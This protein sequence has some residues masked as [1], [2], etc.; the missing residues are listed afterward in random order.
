MQNLL[1]KYV[2]ELQSKHQTGQA[3]EGA[4]RSALE[5]LLEN[6]NKEIKAINEPERTE[7][8]APDLVLMKDDIPRGYV[9]AKDV[10]KGLDGLT[11]SDQLQ[12]Y[13]SAFDNV[14]FTNYLDFYFY[15]EGE[16]YA[17]V[18]IGELQGNE[19]TTQAENFEQLANLLE[20][21]L[22][23]TSRSIKSADKL[24]EIMAEK[25][26]LL[27]D[28]VRNV[29]DD[30]SQDTEVH[31]QFEAFEKVL[32]KDLDED[33]FADMYA[34]TIV[35]GLLA[36][37]YNDKTLDSFSR[38]EAH[39]L[40]PAGNPFLSK[41][42]KHIRGSEYDIR[43]NWIIDDLISAFLASDVHEIMHKEF[44]QKRR[45]PMMHFY[46]TFLG[47][48]DKELKQ[49]RGVFYTPQP[50]VSFITQSVD[51]ILQDKFDL[52][53]GIANTDTVEIEEE[54]QG[55]DRRRKDDK[56]RVKRNVPRVQILDP[57]TGTGTFLNQVIKD[58]YTK[59]EDKKGAWK[60]YVNQHLNPRLWGFELMMAP[61]TMAHLNLDM[62][63]SETGVEDIDDRFGIYLTNTL[64]EPK[65]EVPNL[66][67]TKWLSKE[68]REANRVKE[69]MPIRVVLGNPPYSGISSNKG[70]WITDLIEDYK[71]VD[72]EHFGEKK[73]W[74]GDDYVKFI[75][76]AED[77]IDKTGEGVVAY[78]TNHGYLD[79]PTFRGMRWHLMNTFD[80]IYVL[81]LH[82]NSNKGET[83]PDGPKDENVFDIQQGVAIFLG[84]KTEEGSDELADVY[85][86]EIYG[87]RD[88]KYDYLSDNSWK[89]L[90]WKQ[91]NPQE[92][93]YFFTNK[94]FSSRAEYR[95]GVKLN[96]LFPKNVTGV[97]TARDK[98]AISY[99]KK[100][101]VE[102]MVRF[103]D[104]EKSTEDVREE[105][106]SHKR[107]S[108]YP[109]G[110][111]RGFKVPEA[112]ES[113][114]DNNHAEYVKRIE[115][116]PFDRRYIY[117]S[118]DIVDW[119]RESVL[120]H[121]TNHKNIAL[122]FS[123]QA[124]T[125]GGFSHALVFKSILDN[126][127]FHSNKGIPV[128]APL[129]I[130]PDEDSLFEDG[131]TR[132][133]N[134][135]DDVISEWGSSLGL[136]FTSD[137]QNS[138]EGDQ[139]TFSPLDILDFCYG[140]LYSEHF[141]SKFEEFLEMDFPRIPLV[142][143]KELFWKIVEK[144][145][146]LRK[147]HLME[148]VPDTHTT[149]NGE[150][151]MAVEKYDFSSEDEEAGKI[152]INNNQFF[153]GVSQNVWETQIGGYQVVRTYLRYR[154]RDSKKL[155]YDDVEHLQKVIAI[156]KKTQDIMDELSDLTKQIYE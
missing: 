41:F 100:E 14:V 144:G 124:V 69:D 2:T 105:F 38:E 22:G 120:R 26:K 60:S 76:F 129:Y 142:N 37:R 114:R 87:K 116:R 30:D 35:Y 99:D 83:T 51:Q 137:H 74:L 149:F 6:V 122:G 57:A 21:F 48:Y 135:D 151:D 73:H 17:E 64:E 4:Y 111:S 47:E 52:S 45:D 136:K 143:D 84:V 154:K 54:S 90:G 88:S 107:S 9:E 16:K 12:R 103:A 141:R 118:G 79:N 28:R 65:R 62:T 150:G 61:Y 152:W 94:D 53:D 39:E 126:R 68:S 63:L 7:A 97:V 11:D 20:D 108:K 134:L 36:A 70:D 71:Y 113:I 18:S 156:L 81:D 133:P 43:L 127:A 109:K 1:Q 130:Y 131:E 13:I 85:H 119:P 66:F 80:E 72:G 75:R 106:F 138:N 59:F 148:N 56:K 33:G 112:R 27:R 78:I 91:I 140:I 132:K 86:D 155:T 31:D 42:F 32:I 153:E 55:Y 40:L 139:N 58:T 10:D 77:Q 49:S 146:E 117:Y 93:Y 95:E 89:D 44:E 46:E 128:E 98:F 15:R 29:L 96:E 121:V 3:R 23:R 25:A 123:R 125:E 19:I 101:L 115:Y 147:L 82:G 34:Q 102:R 92:K 110:D 67:M 104:P 50:I 145:K 8:G 5:E 24:A